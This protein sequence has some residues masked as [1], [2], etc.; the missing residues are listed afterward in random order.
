MKHWALSLVVAL[1]LAVAP[2]AVMANGDSFLAAYIAPYPPA[3]NAAYSVR[4]IDIPKSPDYVMVRTSSANGFRAEIRCPVV[5]GECA[6]TATAGSPGLYLID[7]FT[8]SGVKNEKFIGSTAFYA[9]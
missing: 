6:Y 3:A 2:C 5:S 8:P 9:V 7:V 4:L 1:T